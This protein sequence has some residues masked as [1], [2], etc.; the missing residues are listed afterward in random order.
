MPTADRETHAASISSKA[1]DDLIGSPDPPVLA[2]A[3]SNQLDSCEDKPA[4]STSMLL[5]GRLAWSDPWWDPGLDDR[6]ENKRWTDDVIFGGD[7]ELRVREH[8]W[9]A[10]QTEVNRF[11]FYCLPHSARWDSLDEESQTK[12]KAWAP[13]AERFI[14]VPSIGGGMALFEGWVWRILYDNLLS[15]DCDDK[16]NGEHWAAFGKT[17]RSL[18]GTYPQQ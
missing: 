7:I 16:W 6:E 15:Q 17:N 4:W 12:I 13:K 8:L 1:L 2:M 18:R 9:D 5:P 3:A 14:S 11:L 10:S